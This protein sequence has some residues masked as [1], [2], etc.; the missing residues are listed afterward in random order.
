MRHC[1]IFDIGKTNKKAFVFDERYQIVCEKTAQFP[2]TTDDDGDPC[3]DIALLEQWVL[4]TAAE[5]RSDARFQ[6]KAVNCTTYGASF[7]YLDEA[8]RPLAPLYNYL[9]PFPEDLL[10]IF[11]LYY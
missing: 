5:M 4:K 2:E 6:I 9:K 8:L 3:E 1:L 7:V 10:N 11:L